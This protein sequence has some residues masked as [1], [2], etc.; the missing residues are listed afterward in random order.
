VDSIYVCVISAATRVHVRNLVNS[1]LV[2]RVQLSW[3]DTLINQRDTH[4]IP[5]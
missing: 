1:K 4:A 2:S 3:V 5:A